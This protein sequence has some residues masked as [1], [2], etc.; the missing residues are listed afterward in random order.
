MTE[1]EAPPAA[2][3]HPH[4]YEPT[5]DANPS[6]I[7]CGF[8]DRD[9]EWPLVRHTDAQ[10]A[11]PPA[12]EVPPAILEARAE[13][14][15]YR[16]KA[17][18]QSYDVAMPTTLRERMSYAR[19]LAA[20]S[21]IPKA[22]RS[23]RGGDD[24]LR[25]TTANVLLAVELGNTL[26]LSPLQALCQVNVVEGKPSLGAEGQLAQ[27]LK[28]GHDMYVDEERSDRTKATVVAQRDGS[29]RVHTIT[30]TLDDAVAAGLVRMVEGKPYARSQAGKA[31]PWETSTPDML[32]WRAVTR[33]CK[34]V[35]PDVVGG[36]AA[37]DDEPG[38][39]YGSPSA[40]AAAAQEAPARASR[41]AATDSVEDDLALFTEATGPWWVH[42]GATVRRR[43][44]LQLAADR[45]ADAAAADDD[46]VP[47]QDDSA[48]DIVDAVVVEPDEA[49]A[50][51]LADDDLG[52]APAV[53]VDM[54]AEV[55]DITAALAE[56]AA[57]VE[58][59]EAEP[60]YG[61]DSLALPEDDTHGQ[62]AVVDRAQVWATVEALAAERGKTVAQL[63]AR[64]TLATRVNPEDM[65]ADQLQAFLN[66]QRGL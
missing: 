15:L 34:R 48:A 55:A 57:L 7:T 4:P 20:S 60:T 52:T 14:E 38:T 41:P 53:V 13:V 51:P 29:E 22:F 30:Y 6:C 42:A 36:L 2:R 44:K 64:H 43:N 58:P 9:D 10:P 8:D 45:L 56:E 23:G 3:V 12:P 65:T 54:E 61:D 32:V 11:Q 24:G 16:L 31:L 35:F 33:T 27:V 39:Q 25:E 5:S 46:R 49:Q 50:G 37:A 19:A 21:L 28:A 1:T 26:G 66:A 40:G 62:D 17:A 59:A 63:L 47:R 18:E